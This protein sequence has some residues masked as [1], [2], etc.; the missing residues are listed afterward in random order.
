MLL[1]VIGL[2]AFILIH[3][4]P[5][6]PDLRRGLIE[7]FGETP[8]KIAF[9]VVSFAALAL[10]VYGYSKLATMPGKNP[11]LWTPPHWTR[12]ITMLLMLLAFVMLAAAYIPS[13]IRTWLQHPMLAAVKTW[14]VAHLLVRGDAASV[15]LFGAFL[16]YAVYDRISV[17]RRQALGPLGSAT[18]GL[19][20][21]IAVLV[22]GIAAYAVFVLWAHA[23]LFG[24][25]LSAGLSG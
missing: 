22:V 12:H 4:I 1:L 23:A 16:A 20:G 13:H 17:K 7:R 6:A 10:I 18:G 5:T 14:A 2:A 8:Y 25:P 11:V 24:V 9:S 21:D 15:L 3:L 19:T